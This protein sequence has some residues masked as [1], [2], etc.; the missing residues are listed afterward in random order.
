MLLSSAPVKMSCGKEGLFL[1][2]PLLLLL[3]L[4]LFVAWNSL[5]CDA[6]ATVELPFC[7]VLLAREGDEGPA[8]VVRSTPRRRSVSS[9]RERSVTA[10]SST[11]L[12]K[13][14]EQPGQ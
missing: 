9:K 8:E 3:L 4:L 2:L 11:L 1:P 6:V 7:A 14:T 5:M 13:Y 12:W 10:T